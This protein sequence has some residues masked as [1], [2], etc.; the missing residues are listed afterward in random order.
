MSGC[1]PGA[2]LDSGLNP[3][4]VVLQHE[5][6]V[7]YRLPPMAILLSVAGLIPFVVSSLFAA[8]SAVEGG[9]EGLLALVS[10]GA[11]ILSFIGA[12]HWG[13]VLEGSKQPLERARLSLAV[14]PALLG[15]SAVLLAIWHHAP[16]GLVLLIAAYI[17]TVIVEGRGRHY[18][19]VPRSYLIL[20]W[21][22][23]VVAVALMTTVVVLRLLGS[24][25]MD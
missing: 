3:G 10:Y 25:I 13:F 5:D 14:V 12:V 19:L 8:R 16:L 2:H 24:N 9:N 6:A 7:E 11:V 20:R 15:W 4:P 21:G 18:N 22:L 17:G 1:A 23:T